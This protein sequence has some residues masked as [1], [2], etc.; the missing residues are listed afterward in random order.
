LVEHLLQEGR[1]P[2]Q[3]GSCEVTKAS[4]LP[5]T[6]E[7]ERTATPEVHSGPRSKIDSQSLMKRSIPFGVD[8]AVP[9]R[10]AFTTDLSRPAGFHISDLLALREESRTRERRI[11]DSI[12]EVAV[13]DAQDRAEGR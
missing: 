4:A 6:F 10:F 5:F 2:E 11:V 7:D 9:C 3:G 12:P 1:R 8:E 13:G